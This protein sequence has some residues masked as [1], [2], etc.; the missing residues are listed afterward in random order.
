MDADGRYPKNLT[1]NPE[2]EDGFP[3]CSPNGNYDIY[4]MSADGGN[5]INL[6][7]HPALDGHPVW[8]PD[9]S[10][11]AF[12]SWRDGNLEIYVMDADGS[13]VIR[14]TNNPAEDIV[15]DWSPDGQK[16]AFASN[17]D[18]QEKP[19]RWRD[20]R[21]PGVMFPRDMWEIY[22]MDANGRN[23][24]RLTNNRADDGDPSFL[25]IVGRPAAS[26]DKGFALWGCAK[27]VNEPF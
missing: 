23:Q 11:I 7:N 26:S 21:R 10:K 24:I 25:R 8:S 9:S 27:R 4:V 13:N 3:S 6:T 12:D 14:L 19:R 15:Y 2:C 22:V 17:R 5:P 18:W 16:I 1:N 20:R